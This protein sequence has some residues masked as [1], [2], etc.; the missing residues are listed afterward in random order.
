[1]YARVTMVQGSPHQVDAGIDSYKSQVLPAIQGL[2][3]Y[4]GAMLL[5]DRSTGKGL[6][7]SL[8]ATEEARRQ[9]ADAVAKAR[10]ATI[11]A[12]GATVPPVDEYEAVVSDLR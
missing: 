4:K 10:E 2:D 3:G 1:M 12:M 7:L 6:G 5:V 11:E 9:A 8:W